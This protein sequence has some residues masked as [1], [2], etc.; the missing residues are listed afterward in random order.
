MS[1][2]V[3]QRDTGMVMS[4]LWEAFPRLRPLASVI[5]IQVRHL[6]AAGWLW[7]VRRLAAHPQ[8]LPGVLPSS[9]HGAGSHGA[10]L[11]IVDR[12]FYLVLAFEQAQ[13]AGAG[14][15][16]CSLAARVAWLI[17]PA[18]SSCLTRSVSTPSA[19]SRAGSAPAAPASAA[20]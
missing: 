18:V 1:F 7:N 11:G 15:V 19:K 20:R 17:G 5:T 12:V 3:T 2:R 13:M 14:A 6:P 16:S 4:A 8:G 9:S 10:G